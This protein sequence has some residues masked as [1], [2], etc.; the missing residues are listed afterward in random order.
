MNKVTIKSL[1]SA[2]VRMDNSVDADR[3]Y[4]IAANVNV[5]GTEVTDTNG[6]VRPKGDSSSVIASFNSY[7]TD[8]LS[9]N[10]QGINAEQQQAVNAAINAFI[11]DAKVKAGTGEVF[12]ANL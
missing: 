1:N 7:G 9:V 5:S 2:N 6:E 8:N 11:S 12:N 4:D 10:Y 3:V